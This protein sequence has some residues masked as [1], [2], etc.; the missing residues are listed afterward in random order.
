MREYGVWFIEELCLFF[1]NHEPS[2]RKFIFPICDQYF[3]RDYA[4]AVSLQG[5]SRQFYRYVPEM[6]SEYKRAL[7]YTRKLSTG[8]RLRLAQMMRAFSA[9]DF[10]PEGELTDG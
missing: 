7:N 10:V 3:I 9:E 2:Y 6:L 1:C 8:E 5:A 4:G